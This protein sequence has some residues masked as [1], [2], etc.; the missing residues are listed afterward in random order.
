MMGKGKDWRRKL[1]DD[2][3]SEICKLYQAGRSCAELAVHFH[4]TPPTISRWLT[5]S[6]IEIRGNRKLSDND[7]EEICDLYKSCRNATEVAKRFSVDSKTVSYHLHKHNI[8]TS[9]YTYSIGQPDF[10]KDV[11]TERKAYWVGLIAADGCVVE[12]N[13]TLQIG[14]LASDRILL[15]EFLR[16]IEA[17]HPIH[18]KDNGRYAR[19]EITAPA[20]IRDLEQ[21]NIIPRK[22]FNLVWPDLIP[23]SLLSHYMRGFADGDGGFYFRRPK[24]GYAPRFSFALSSACVPFLARFRD[25]LALACRIPPAK[26]LK[27]KGHNTRMFSYCGRLRVRS[28]FRFLYRDATI[29]LPRKRDKVEPHLQLVDS[30]QLGLPW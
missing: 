6:G 28:I 15:E 12:C 25:E 19:I 20:M 17:N 29:W 22:T 23:R 4:V 21:F 10:F 30:R 24:H 8:A 18:E 3:V 9:R 13:N 2:D 7:I 16:D 14:F 27:Q 11:D 1:T 5:R 26:I